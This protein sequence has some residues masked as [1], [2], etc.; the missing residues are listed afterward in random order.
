MTYRLLQK[1]TLEGQSNSAFLEALEDDEVAERYSYPVDETK[2]WQISQ[3]SGIPL[4]VQ[5]DPRVT[6]RW[7]GDL[8]WEEQIELAKV[9]TLLLQ[10]EL[11][12]LHGEIQEG[13]IYFLILKSDL[14]QR[15]F[16]RTWVEYQQT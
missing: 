2:Y 3:L 4:P 7:A 10:V 15:R 1:W 13:T 16:D 12:D 5:N 9:W 8:E 6:V 11:S 14:E